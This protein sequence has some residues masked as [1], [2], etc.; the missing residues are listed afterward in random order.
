MSNEA[1]NTLLKLEARDPE[2]TRAYVAESAHIEAIDL[3]METPR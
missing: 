3:S 1:F 2:F